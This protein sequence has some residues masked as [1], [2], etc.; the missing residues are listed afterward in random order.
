MKFKEFKEE[1]FY[2]EVFF[3]KIL[4]E[5][6]KIASDPDLIQDDRTYSLILKIEGKTSQAHLL[7]ATLIG[8]T[9]RLEQLAKEEGLEDNEEKEE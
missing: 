8:W 7:L 1:L 6:E 4:K 5:L 2:L 9:Q 3:F